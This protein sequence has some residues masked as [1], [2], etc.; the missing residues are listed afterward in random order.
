[1]WQCSCS[2]HAAHDLVTATFATTCLCSLTTS[3]LLPKRPDD[4]KWAD[5][6]FS[7]TSQAAAKNGKIQHE[8]F[9][10]ATYHEGTGTVVEAESRVRPL[11]YNPQWEILHLLGPVALIPVQHLG[12]LEHQSR[13]DEEQHISREKAMPDTTD[14]LCDN[15]GEEGGRLALDS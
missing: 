14:K 11:G 1:M 4:T 10:S 15:E 13:A 7:N 8:A 6:A 12:R 3:L 5:R 9:I 2:T